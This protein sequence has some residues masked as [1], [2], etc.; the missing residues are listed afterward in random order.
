MYVPNML[1]F[2]FAQEMH[3]SINEGLQP[4]WHLQLLIMA[5]GG[6]TNLQYVVLWE[7]A[8]HCVHYANEWGNPTSMRFQWIE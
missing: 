1:F 7:G 3:K 5:F 6:N 8:N 4:I 2:S